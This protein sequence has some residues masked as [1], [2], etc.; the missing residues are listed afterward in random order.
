MRIKLID[1]ALPDYTKGEEMLNMV[2]HI[3]GGVFAAAALALCLIKSIRADNASS[4]AC[5][6]VYGVSTIIL[7][8]MSSVYHGLPASMGKKVMQV[9]DHCAIYLMIAGTYTPIA[10]CALRP[11]Y[12]ALAWSIF[13][14]EWG[15]SALAIVLTAIDLKQYA[16]FSMACYIVMGWCIGAFL[17]QAA[18]AM[19]VSGVNLLLA[20]GVC[21]TLGAVLYGIGAKKRWFHGVFHVFVL[22][23][24]VL[25]FLCIYIYV[26]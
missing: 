21:Y 25:H 4:I 19:S 16:V 26:I 14:M 23:G 6:V 2:T 18:A 1:R 13:G 10:L 24:S 11:L 9:L 15:L 8:C 20:G 3:A 5:S 22:A 7:Y 12:P 17:P